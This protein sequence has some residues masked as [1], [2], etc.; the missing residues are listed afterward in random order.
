MT[1]TKLIILAIIFALAF[2][3]FAAKENKLGYDT[4]QK[5]SAVLNGKKKKY[6]APVDSSV[7]QTIF[8][9]P[10]YTC[11]GYPTLADC[12]N[13]RLLGRSDQKEAIQL[14]VNWIRKKNKKPDSRARIAVSLVQKI[15]Y[16]T[17][18]YEHG[19]TSNRGHS[20]RYPYETLY[21]NK[22]ICS[23]KS[24]LMVLLLKEL[25]FGTATMI[26][27]EPELHQVAGVKCSSAYDFQDTGYCF[28]GPNYRRMITSAG[29]YEGQ[30]PDDLIILSDG[31]TFNAKNDWKDAQTW[32]RLLKEGTSSSKNY[33]KYKKLVKK[34]GI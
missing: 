18:W 16:D 14:L 2:P 11:Q 27:D 31:R 5:V 32:R 28:I 29:Y 30:N 19:D 3:A 15:P 33:K 34:Y 9:L 26:F 1:K 20:T 8:N 23:H 7:Y 17:E 24:F 22:G 4:S 25:G 21:E 6:N 13:D 12:Y 10:D